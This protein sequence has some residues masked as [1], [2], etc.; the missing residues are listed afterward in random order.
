MSLELDAIKARADAATGG[1]WYWAYPGSAKPELIGRAGDEHY[2]FETEIIEVEHDGGCGC[3]MVCN[4]TVSVTIADAEFIAHSRADVPALVAEVE[5]LRTELAE[6]RM[7]T[8]RDG[9]Q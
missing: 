7:L 5:R 2:A 1:P 4:Q 8:L 3:R 6:A 9:E